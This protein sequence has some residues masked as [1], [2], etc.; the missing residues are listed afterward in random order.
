MEKQLLNLQGLGYCSVLER[1]G[2]VSLR[3]DLAGRRVCVPSTDNIPD[4]ARLKYE[5]DT[6]SELRFYS[7]YNFKFALRNLSFSG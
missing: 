6:F 5:R 4:S 7:I 3:L 2:R 1:A